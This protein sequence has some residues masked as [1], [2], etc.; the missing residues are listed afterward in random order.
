MASSEQHLLE[1]ARGGDEQAFA[2]LLEPYRGELHAHCYRLVA[3]VHDA[4]EVLQDTLVRAWR[5]LPGFAGRSSLRTW[6]YTI[7]TNASLTFIRRRQRRALPMEYGPP[8]T[9]QTSEWVAVESGWVEP[10][11]DP[12]LGAVAGMAGPAARYEMREAV[13]LA[14]IAACQ[15]LPATQRAVLILRDV[16]SFSAKETAASLGT[17]EAS[18]TSALQRARK[19]IATRLPSRSQQTSL[20]KLGDERTRQLVEDYVGAWERGDAA[21]ILAMLADDAT[22]SMPPYSLW[23]SGRDAIAEF[24]PIGPLQVRWRLLPVG[25]SGQLAF[26]CYAWDPERGCYVGHSIDVLAL[27]GDTITQIVAYLELEA[28]TFLRFGLPPKILAS[29]SGGPP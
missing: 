7:A 5:G 13:E 26:G 14:F 19:T 21:A 9:P 16:L 22:F 20:R 10:Y 1:G 6:L 28:S 25:A 27:R 23:Y 3:S 17:T 24:L 8:G 11:P 18:V 15:H 12:D 29:H 2:R 4:D